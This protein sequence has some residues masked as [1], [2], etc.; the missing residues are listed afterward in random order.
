MSAAAGGVLSVLKV[1]GV[2]ELSTKYFGG[3]GL[4]LRLFVAVTVKK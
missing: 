2:K 3:D 1:N 4:L